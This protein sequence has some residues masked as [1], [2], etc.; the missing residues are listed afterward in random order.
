MK[1]LTLLFTILIAGIYGVAQI[2]INNNG[3]AI[4]DITSTTKGLLIPRMTNIYIQAITNPAG[5]LLVYSTDDS[6]TYCFHS[7]DNEWKELAIGTSGMTPYAIYNIGTSSVL[8]G[9]IYEGVTILPSSINLL[10]TGNIS[11]S[12]YWSITT[13]VINGYSFSGSGTATSTGTAYFMLYASGTP[14]VAQTDYFNAIANN[15]GGSWSFNVTV[16]PVPSYPSGTVHCIAGGA[17]I[18]DVYNPTT[19]E[20][21]MDRNLGASQVATSATDSDAYGDLYQWGRLSDGHQCRSSGT[22]TTLSSNNVPGHDNFIITSYSPYDWRNPQYP[23]LWQ[24]ESGINN[25]CPEGY[26]I[27][28]QAEWEA[29]RLSWSSG[30]FSS[31]LKLSRTGVR[32]TSGTINNAGIQGY[33]WSSTYATSIG[34]YG[35]Y[36]SDGGASTTSNYTRS[37]GFSVRCIKD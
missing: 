37:Q 10:I 28:T 19:G 30:A 8:T 34:S 12:G 5:G 36:I 25:P 27:P 13:A 17:E 35:L 26:R 6:K 9:S 4:L 7:D 15:G 32:Y 16:N 21:W 1:K 11:V 18:N 23:L 31:P 33:Y 2:A 22:T 29:E 20:T 24:G 14:V 3:S